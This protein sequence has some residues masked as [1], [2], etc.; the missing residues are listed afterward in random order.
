MK[1]PVIVPL[2]GSEL[3]E[4]ALPLAISMAQRIGADVLLWRVLRLP[5]SDIEIT[6]DKVITISEQITTSRYYAEMYL[7]RIAEELKQEGISSVSYAAAVG[8]P[9]EMIASV[10]DE[11][12][13]SY[14]VMSTHGYSSI[15]RWAVGSVAN[16]VLHLTQRPLILMRPPLPAAPRDISAEKEEKP[17]L[18]LPQIKR[19]VVPLE[20]LPLAEQIFPYVKE[21]AHAYGE[22]DIRL[23]HAVPA[24]PAG[25][26]PL[27]IEKFKRRWMEI[28][29]QKAQ[30][31]LG[32]FVSRLWAER[33]TVQLAIRVGGAADEILEYVT[34]VDADLIMMTTHA[35][36]G[37]SRFLLGSVTDKVVRAGQVPVLVIR[38]AVLG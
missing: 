29:Y 35:R 32:H 37:L 15:T 30:S 5:T 6:P 9:G 36:E 26:V 4:Q 3:A 2:D 34:E 17:A 7:H 10:A 16:R 27:E 24:F 31:Y 33:H 38:P 22:V 21:V 18:V 8:T 19:I 28:C 1:G 25:L 14:I 13:A 20:G 12:K 23:F 11:R